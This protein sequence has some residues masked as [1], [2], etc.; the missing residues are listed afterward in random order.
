MRKHAKIDP[1]HVPRAAQAI[2]ACVMIVIALGDGLLSLTLNVIY[3]YQDGLPSA[4]A[5]GLA[6]SA[7]ITCLLAAGLFGWTMRYALITLIC[8]S[9]SLFAALNIYMNGAGAALAL[10]EHAVAVFEDN[11]QSIEELQR[12][13]ERLD[14]LATEEGKRKGCRDICKGLQDRAD[15]ARE[16]LQAA[17]LVRA[18]TTPP[19][20]PGLA[21][22]LGRLGAGDPATVASGMGVGKALAFLVAMELIVWFAPLGIVLLMQA[23]P[24]QAEAVAV[25]V[26]VLA[27]EPVAALPKPNASGTRDY[28]LQRLERDFPAIAERVR[29]GDVSVYRASV[30]AGIRKRADQPKSKRWTRA[31]DYA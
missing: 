24:Q 1:K 5:Y 17:R 15:K 14:T 29:S 19:Q 11:R 13:V 3:G 18:E 6:D 16:D 26:E 10:R 21:S 23:R 7:K 4:I 20:I 2:L 31:S 25:E 30:E 9:I 27:P 12:Q 22:F 28:Y 8:A